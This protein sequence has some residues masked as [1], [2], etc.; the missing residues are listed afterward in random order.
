MLLLPEDQEIALGL[1]SYREVIDQE[2]PTQSPHYAAMV[3]RVGARIA[4][5]ADRPDYEWE[6]RVI[7]SPEQNAF[8][9]PG[10]KVAVYEGILPICENEAGVAVVVAHEIAHALAR[11]GGERM[12][13]QMAANGLGMA[14]SY[15]MRDQDEKRQELIKQGYALGSKYGVI[16]PYSRK[17]ELEADHIGLI[18]MAKAGYDPQ[19][20]PKFWE[21]FAASHPG[22][23]PPEF[24]STHP[25]DARRAEDLRGLLA[26]ATQLYEAAQHKH[27]LG[28]RLAI[29]SP[30]DGVAA[31]PVAG[32]PSFAPVAEAMNPPIPGSYLPAIQR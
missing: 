28:E 11:H 19:E 30:P 22:Q 24:L 23:Q 32:Q 21:R 29:A 31:Q 9:L 20:A 7:A 14:V 4:A 16:L 1:S 5:V 6:F 3:Q 2:P 17:H 10:G 25:H 27:G 8:C 26:E 12:S 18:L 15:V 13:Q